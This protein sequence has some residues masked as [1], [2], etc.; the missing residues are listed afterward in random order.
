MRISRI[1][2]SLACG[3]ILLL[4]VCFSIRV[5]PEGFTAAASTPPVDDPN[6]ALNDPDRFAWSIFTAINK[7]AG[8]GTNDSVWETWA[9]QDD[10]YADPNHE[11]VWPGAAHQPKRLRPSIKLETFRQMQLQRLSN[12][13]RILSEPGK[14]E[15]NLSAFLAP[16]PLSEEVRM[17]KA[18]FDFIV[19]NG[20]WHLDGQK[21]AFNTVRKVSFPIDAKE[22][23][24]HWKQITEADKPRY[25]WQQ[26]T[27]GKTFGLIA[28]H[29]MTK[30]LPNW[31]WAT[32]EHVDNPRRCKVNGCKDSFGVDNAGNVSQELLQMFL[33]STMGSEWQNYRLTGAQVDFTDST[34]RPTILGNSEIEGPFMATSSCITCHAKSSVNGSG[35]R[36]DFFTP[37]FQSD[38]GVPNPEWFYNTGASP[39]TAKYT[40]LDFVWSLMLALPKG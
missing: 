15:A 23:K 22:V 28:L 32:W 35:D 7:S 39:Q 26:G 14:K 5:G 34:G 29:I 12:R 27:D 25:H 31:F 8:N 33:S 16:N 13:S 2:L 6:P 19:K 21:A 11:P 4:A 1:Y 38:N 36:L 20:L 24:A 37:D 30:D 3:A 18:N 10:V 9:L 40:Q 17:N